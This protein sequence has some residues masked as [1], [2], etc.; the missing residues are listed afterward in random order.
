MSCDHDLDPEYLYPSD[1]QL[2]DIFEEDDTLSFRLALPCPE[3]D[4]AFEIVARADS[5]EQA[6]Y[7]LPLD[8]V[9][10]PYD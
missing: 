6:E 4:Q 8:D 2:I 3:C 1:A 7:E 10:E 9:E 5:I